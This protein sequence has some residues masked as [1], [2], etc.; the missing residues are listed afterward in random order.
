M[1]KVN[2]PTATW[3][4]SQPA[5]VGFMWQIVAESWSCSAATRKVQ[6]FRRGQFF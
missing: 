6:S 1:G 3:E 2:Q 5:P 4:V